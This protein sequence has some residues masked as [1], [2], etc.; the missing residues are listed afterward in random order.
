MSEAVNTEDHPTRIDVKEAIRKAKAIVADFMEGETY[1]QLGLE[2]VKYDDRA[3]QWVITLGINRPWNVEKESRG[4]NAI[5]GFPTT[6]SRQ[7]RTYK[8]VMLK[9]K[10]GEFVSMED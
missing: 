10:T 1:S 8:K 9:G 2:E 5:Y 4:S 3:D 6:V 7:L